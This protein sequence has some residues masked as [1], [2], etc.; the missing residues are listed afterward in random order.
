MRVSITAYRRALLGTRRVCAEE[1]K[2][3][4][5]LLLVASIESLIS[6]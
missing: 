2:F 6:D 4:L 1:D 3:A 5:N